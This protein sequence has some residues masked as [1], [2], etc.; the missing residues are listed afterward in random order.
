MWV[1][2]ARVCARPWQRPRVGFRS[3]QI[4][5]F[6][7]SVSHTLVWRC[8]EP[9]EAADFANLEGTTEHFVAQLAAMDAAAP[10]SFRTV[11]FIQTLVSF[12]IFLLF[13]LSINS[14]LKNWLNKSERLPKQKQMQTQKRKQHAIL[15][16]RTGEISCKTLFLC[17]NVSS[18]DIANVSYIDIA[19][20][21]N[22]DIANVSNIDFANVSFIDIANV[23]YIDIA[24]VSYINSPREV[25]DEDRARADLLL[26][27]CKT[28]PLRLSLEERSL[29]KLLEGALK[30]SEYTDRVD[31]STSSYGGYS[32]GFSST[33]Y[34]AG[35]VSKKTRNHASRTRSGGVVAQRHGC[36]ARLQNWQTSMTILLL[37]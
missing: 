3:D 7:I 36:C 34:S 10:V 24:N 33:F 8:R 25:S 5:L 9:L 12:L 35:T 14:L 26:R 31:V 28:T 30:V 29:L 22:I 6:G 17:A 15:L 23:S 19:N 11:G 16:S 1:V 18:V 4:S 20:V 21:S 2:L 27:M 32:Y 37:I 13:Y